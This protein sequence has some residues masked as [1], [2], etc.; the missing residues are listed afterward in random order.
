[1]L[2]VPACAVKNAAMTPVALATLATL[3]SISAQRT[4]NVSPTAMIPVTDISERMFLRL[5][6]DAN[7][8]LA[9]LKNT[10]SANNMT[11]GAAAA[12]CLFRAQRIFWRLP[13]RTAFSDNVSTAVPLKR[14]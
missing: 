6:S 7:L 5:S 3:K 2:T 12:L 8:G 13:S 11:N 1:M 9:M 10:R 14:Q 4:T